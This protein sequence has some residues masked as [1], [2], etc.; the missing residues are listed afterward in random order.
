MQLRSC[1]SS[2]IS[3]ASW[4]V[5]LYLLESVMI[6]SSPLGSHY[7]FEEQ[8]TIAGNYRALE[9]KH[10]A[11]QPSKRRPKPNHIPVLHRFNLIQRHRF[12]PCSASAVLT[13]C[14]YWDV[15]TTLLWTR[16]A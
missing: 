11:Y 10:L 2:F 9:R 13:L 15:L 5:L 1:A 14:N 4:P 7:F 12:H 16:G 3:L 8:I 6:N